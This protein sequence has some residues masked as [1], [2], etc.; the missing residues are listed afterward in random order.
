MG[1]LK[2]NDKLVV[3]AGTDSSTL[4]EALVGF[5]NMYN[6]QAVQAQLRVTPLSENEFAITFPSDISFE[7]YCYLVN[8]LRYP[9]DI[10]WTADVTGWATTKNGD[11]WITEKTVNKKGMFFVPEDDNE[12]DNVY[13]TT[14]D[15]SGY[16]LSFGSNKEKEL[17]GPLRQYQ[18][19][20]VSISELHAKDHV[21]V[22]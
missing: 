4:K 11:E 19:P 14:S 10:S 17:K 16:K 2:L 18:E 6:E 3:V 15:N 7:I 5:C 8:Y 9:I 12:H 22:R 21:D 13:M 20:P 1:Q